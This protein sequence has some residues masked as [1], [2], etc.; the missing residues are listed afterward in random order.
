MPLYCPRAAQVTA[1]P[2]PL[3]RS[4]VATERFCGTVCQIRMPFLACKGFAHADQA[5]VRS[6]ETRCHLEEEALRL[7]VPCPAR[8]KERRTRASARCNRAVESGILAIAWGNRGRESWTRAIARRTR[9]RE[10]GAFADPLSASVWEAFRF[11]LR[12][13]QSHKPRT[14]DPAKRVK[15][16]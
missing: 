3:S 2:L 4:R 14:A 15:A 11:N 10:Q 7:A 13:C 16:H 12:F 8:A 1:F 6:E 9:A 5:Q